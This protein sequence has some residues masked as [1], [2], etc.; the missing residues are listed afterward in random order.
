MIRP[1]LMNEAD[2]ASYIGMSIAFLRSGRCHG[3]VG[4][5]TPTPPHLKLGRSVK[6]ARVDLDKWLAERRID[7][8]RRKTRRAA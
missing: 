7:P 1:E 3:I 2:A 8:A 4:N 5:R 6:Y